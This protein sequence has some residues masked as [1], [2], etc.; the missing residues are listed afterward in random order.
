MDASELHDFPAC[1][2]VPPIESHQFPAVGVYIDKRILPGF[3][4]RIRPLPDLNHANEKLKCMFSGNAL[5]LKSIGRGYAR[6]F[7]LIDEKRNVEEHFW[8][9]N[10]QEGYAFELE[11][12]SECDKF[13][14]FDA[15]GEAQ[16]TAEVVKIEVRLITVFFYCYCYQ[17]TSTI[18]DLFANFR[19]YAE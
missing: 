2:T 7:T 15:N 17:L 18:N 8:S 9:D 4:Y 16:G 13:T 6:R 11:V 19:S 14:V 12:I 1:Y 5:T 10:R 3:K